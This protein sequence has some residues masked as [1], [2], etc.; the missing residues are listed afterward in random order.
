MIVEASADVAISIETLGQEIAPKEIVTPIELQEELSVYIELLE[1]SEVTV[2]LA[3]LEELTEI[4]QSTQEHIETVHGVLPPVERIEQLLRQL[5]E[6]LGEEAVETIMHAWLTPELLTQL[7]ES[8]KLL[9]D[10]FNY[11]GTHE[12][13]SNSIISMSTKLLKLIKKTVGPHVHIG[14]Y[15][16]SASLANGI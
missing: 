9:I 3:T 15:V 11:I 12:Y 13:K 7:V 2:A 5:L 16:L 8:D 14:K 4:I 1:P 10:Q 6:S